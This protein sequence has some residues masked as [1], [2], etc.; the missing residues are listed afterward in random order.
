MFVAPLLLGEFQ[1]KVELWRI[2]RFAKV[3]VESESGSRITDF[4]LVHL[5]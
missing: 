2:R 5:M 4:R 1:K 3:K